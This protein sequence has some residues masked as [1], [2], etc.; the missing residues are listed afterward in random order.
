[1]AVL[2]PV[3]YHRI[4]VRRDRRPWLVESANRIARAGLVLAATSV[5]QAIA[6]PG[7]DQGCVL[8]DATGE[9]QDVE[10]T[11]ARGHRGDRLAETVQIDVE[12]Q[13]GVGVACLTGSQ[14]LAQV[15]RRPA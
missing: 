12:G 8:A 4:L 13:R 6:G 9:D 15:T 14:H 2:A 1:M 5:G 7:T 11:G 10:A 3:A